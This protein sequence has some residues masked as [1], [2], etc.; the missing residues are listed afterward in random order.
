MRELTLLE[1]GC[2]AGGLLCCLVLPWLM[3]FRGPRDAA[4]RSSCLKTVWAGQL[5]LALAGLTVLASP[6]AVPYAVSL[7][8]TGW[9]A[10]VFRLLRQF[11]V[12]RHSLQERRAA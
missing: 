6:L 7:G 11:R 8:L 5:L 2:L 4:A 9:T 3:S 10:C 1:T 12:A